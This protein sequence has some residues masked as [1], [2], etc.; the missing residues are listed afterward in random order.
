MSELHRIAVRELKPERWV[1]LVTPTEL[2]NDVWINSLHKSGWRIESLR[3]FYAIASLAM[4]RVLVDYARKRLA[5][6]RNS[7]ETLRP[8][9]EADEAWSAASSEKIIEIGLLLE[10]LEKVNSEAARVVDFHYF[11]GFTIEET[12]EITGLSVRQVR[13]RWEKARDWLKE[14]LSD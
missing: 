5:Q 2:I 1:A 9:S 10:E 3:Q 7:G 13:H 11:A 8:L 14:R 6:R 4:R 12:A